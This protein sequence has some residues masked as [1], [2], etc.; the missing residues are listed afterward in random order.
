MFTETMVIE[1]WDVNKQKYVF[2][3]R[4][5]IDVPSNPPSLSAFLIEKLNLADVAISG[6]QF[7]FRYLF[8]YS[9]LKQT[10][11]DNEDIMREKDWPHNLKRKATF[12]IIFNLFDATLDGYKD[13]LKKKAAERDKLNIRLQGIKDFLINSDLTDMAE[14]TKQAK[15]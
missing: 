12:E 8:K 2:Y 7:S 10:E 1:I 4:C 6:N 15:S 13:T 5:D 9:Y 11:I 14:Y 3:T